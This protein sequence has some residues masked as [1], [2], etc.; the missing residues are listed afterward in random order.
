[1]PAVDL[2]RSMMHDDAIII[3]SRDL[4]LIAIP[5]LGLLLMSYFHLDEVF[6]ASK[7]PRKPRRPICGVDEDGR[8]ILCDPDGRP[9]FPPRVGR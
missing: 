8:Q 7:S 4:L 1:M 2:R 9:W 6:I 5:F 3:S